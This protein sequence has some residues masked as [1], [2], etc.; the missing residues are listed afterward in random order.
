MYK[1]QTYRDKFKQFSFRNQLSLTLL[2]LLIATSQ[3]TLHNFSS[4]ADISFQKENNSNYQHLLQA[5]NQKRALQSPSAFHRE[6][7]PNTSP[8]GLGHTTSKHTDNYKLFKHNCNTD[9]YRIH[10]ITDFLLINPPIHLLIV[11]KT[12]RKLK[13][14]PKNNRQFCPPKNWNFSKAKFQKPISDIPPIPAIS[15]ISPSSALSSVP[16]QAQR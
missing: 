10:C 6:G 4:N 1:H 12:P 5:S 9:R 16:T 3:N 15:D 7:E 2:Y 14:A 8:T 13:L 11:I